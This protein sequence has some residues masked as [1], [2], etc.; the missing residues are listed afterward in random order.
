MADGY[1]DREW[2]EKCGVAALVDRKGERNVI[3]ELIHITNGLQHRGELGA[4][5]SWLRNRTQRECIGVLKGNGLVKDVLFPHLNDQQ[6]FS[7]A[8]IGHTRYA[9]SGSCD[10]CLAQPFHYQNGSPWNTFS[11]AFN[12]NIANYRPMRTMLEEQGVH[13]NC[14]VDTEL[15]GQFIIFLMKKYH[16]EILSS[17]SANQGTHAQ[18]EAKSTAMTRSVREQ[19]M[20]MVFTKLQQCLDGA[21]NIVLLNGEGE[22][23]AYR[24]RWEFRPLVYAKHDG[25]VAIASEDSAIREVWHDVKARTIN[26]GELLKA[27]IGGRDAKL[28]KL[29]KARPKHCFFEWVYFSDQG[30]R[31]NG[32]GVSGSRYRSGKLLAAADTDMPPGQL[33]VPVPES[34]KPA[35]DGYA[36]KRRLRRVD[37]L[38]KNPGIGRTFITHEGR[39][40]KAL[41]K[42]DI[43]PTVIRGRPIILDDDSIVRGT[44]MRALVKNLR[45]IAAPSEIHLR[46]AS[47][48]IVAPC[49]YGI[50]FATTSEL[51]V[52]KYSDGTL[53]PD[54]TLPQDVL[55]AIAK[56]LDV[57]SIR[58]LPVPSVPIA[59]RKDINELCM[60]CVTQEYPTEAGQERYSLL[61]VG[62][63][64][65]SAGQT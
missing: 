46:I 20:R 14:D 48:P 49:F 38:L 3:A 42:Y 13:L 55:D 44:T 61:Q 60:A 7:S 22:I 51:L 6:L 2:M 30:S 63:E 19:V 8:A 54:G 50:D 15:I 47:P 28:M 57:D 52:R 29:F 26:G 18:H 53:L 35:A 45:E 59:L 43:D 56:D 23:Y 27:R 21:F 62:T 41:L 64:L 5:L 34:A 37:A 4:G 39:E 24:D 32:V 36:D 40:A 33:V 10:D 58:Y 12:G 11:L 9:T 16:D 65:I 17:E 31:I 25:M 1:S